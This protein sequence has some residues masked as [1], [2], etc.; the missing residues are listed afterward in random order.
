MPSTNSAVNKALVAYVP[1]LHAGYLA[2]FNKH[3]RV[4]IF[5]LGK[6]FIDAFPRLNRDLRALAPIEIVQAL[7]SLGFTATVLEISDAEIAPQ[8]ETVILPDE[9]VSRDFAEKYLTGKDIVFENIFLRWDGR[10]PDVQKDVSPDRVTST[11]ELDREFMRK[12]VVESQKSPDWWRQIGAVLVKDGKIF[13]S[14]HTQHFPS[15]HALD[16]FGTP[17]SNYDWGQRPDVYIA[18]HSEA[19]VVAQAAREGVSTAGALLY[20]STFPC[21]NCAFLIARAGIRKVFYKEGYSNLD[22]EGVLKSAD[23]EII[24]VADA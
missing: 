19:G 14:A 18:M 5:V 21:M 16:I 10:R 12:A 11:E 22:S 20:T 24:F 8:F 17:R 1:A 9:D 23:V 3:P 4:P 6:S 7:A 15:D 2:F 13:L